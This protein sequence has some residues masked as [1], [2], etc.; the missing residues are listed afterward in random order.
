M[1]HTGSLASRVLAM[2]KHRGW[3]LHWT[4][5]GAYLH[6]ESSE[7]I[8]AVRGKH[9]TVL[10]EAGDVLLV[11]MS[12]T[13]AQGIPWQEVEAQA[14]KKCDYL[15]TAPVYDGEQRGLEK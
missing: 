3:S 15:M 7:L 8:E 12:I 10:K 4:A 6:L 14:A 5:R 13:E 1:I 11:L 2:C 9:G